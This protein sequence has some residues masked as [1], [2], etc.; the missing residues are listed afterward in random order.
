LSVE[1]ER[2]YIRE[3]DV[4]NGQTITRNEI[5]LQ[6]NGKTYVH[7]HTEL[8]TQNGKLQIIYLEHTPEKEWFGTWEHRDPY[9]FAGNLTSPIPDK[10]HRLTTDYLR[11]FTGNYVFDSY[12]IIRSDNLR[13]DINLI[14]NTI[15]KIAYSQEKKC[16]TIPLH[17]LRSLYSNLFTVWKE[18]IDFVETSAE[19]PFRWIYAEGVGFSE[20]RFFFYK[21]GIA[22][23]YEYSG[24]DLDDDGERSKRKY[25]KYVV[26]LEKE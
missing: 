13:I 22:F 11:N 4:V 18:P 26:F 19:E 6:I 10:V 12:K 9:T 5:L 17:N 1:N 8:E 23:T 7:N 3:I 16:L 14:K 20:E 21:G 25:I 15:I 24:F 2:V